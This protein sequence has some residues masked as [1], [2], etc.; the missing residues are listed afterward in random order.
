MI[1]NNWVNFE[2]SHSYLKTA[3]ATFRQLLKTF[4]LLFNQTSG[5]TASNI[6]KSNTLNQNW[7]RC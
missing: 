6:E 1:G 7:E 2:K 3:L 4:G 5:H